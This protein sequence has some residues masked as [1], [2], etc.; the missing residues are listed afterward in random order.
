MAGKSGHRQFGTIR[1]LPSGRW[2]ASYLAPD[3]KRRPAESTFVTKA[4][5][6]RWL[7]TVETDMLRGNWR[8]PEPA[9]EAFGPYAEAWL[10]L[11]VGRNGE[12][13]SPTT[14]ELYDLLWR[15]WLRPTF[16]DVALGDLSIE[17]VRTW[18][19]KSRKA[20]PTTT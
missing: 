18:L 4:E 6:G 2:Q 14:A 20:H 10:A 1:K 8:P 15:K 7:S 19:A 11:G 3:G 12:P 9:R 16:A 17:R 13:L 5:A